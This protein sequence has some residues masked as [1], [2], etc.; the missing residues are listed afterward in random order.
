MATAAQNTFGCAEDWAKANI[1]AVFLRPAV[2]LVL[3]Q[4]VFGKMKDA[5]KELALCFW[6]KWERCQIQDLLLLKSFNENL[7]NAATENLQI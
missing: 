6:G 1:Q 3:L 5:D 7:H 4:P 2:A